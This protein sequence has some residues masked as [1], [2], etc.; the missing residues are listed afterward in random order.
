[1]VL[2]VPI[3]D[4]DGVLIASYADH[5]A[6][7]LVWIR[8]LLTD[9][10][11][12]KVFPQLVAYQRL[13]LVI[14]NLPSAAVSVSFVLPSWLNAFNEEVNHSALIQLTWSLEMLVNGPEL[15]DSS[16][17]SDG[18]WLPRVVGTRLDVDPEGVV[19]L[20]RHF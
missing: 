10:S 16:K 2:A 6:I 15:V 13:S 19:V 7:D 8:E 11:K 1:M 20:Q 17:V 12:H 3:P 5:D 14:A 9:H 4:G 18:L